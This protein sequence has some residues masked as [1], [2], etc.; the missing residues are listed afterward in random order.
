MSF[1]FTMEPRVSYLSELLKEI[2]E[3]FLKIPRFQRELVWKP[4]QQRDLLCSIFE[5]LP[6]GALLVW[7]T[8]L[9]NINVYDRIGPFPVR[10]DVISGSNLYLMDGL[11]RLSTLYGTLIYPV[12][13]VEPSRRGSLKVKELS[14]YCDLSAVDVENLFLFESELDPNVRSKSKYV[15]MPL[16]LVFKSKELLR[17]QRTIPTDKEELLDRSDAIVTAF[18]NY[19][20]PVIPLESDDQ[21]LVTKSFERINSR[22]TVMS[23]AHMLNAL[24]YSDEFDLLGSI[25]RNREIFL[26]GVPKWRDIDPE[27]VL[28]LL[29]LN[30]GFELYSKDTDKLAKSINN[31]VVAEVFRAISKLSLF[32]ERYLNIESPAEFPY[33]L[34]MLGVAHAYM[35]RPKVSYIRLRSWFYITTYTNSFGTTARNSQRALFDLKGY[36][37]SGALKWTLSHKPVI[38]SLDGIQVN[39]GAARVKAWTLALRKKYASALDYPDFDFDQRLSPMMPKEFKARGR[40]PGF[41]FL[42]NADQYKSFDVGSLSEDEFDAHFVNAKLLKLY[43]RK[44]YNGFALERERLMFL[45][46]QEN[47][48]MPAATTAKIHDMIK[49]D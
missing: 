33:R 10:S 47:I 34:Q 12:D 3:G 23:E 21:A 40:R 36:L 2:Y 22:G 14:V 48:I 15:Y 29:K 8:R 18:K 13:E 17:F 30:L 42:L 44:D 32:A 37:T 16:S 20:I 41:Y 24:S 6:I 38:Q 25:E 39:T 26:E 4:Q 9:G 1:K 31:D 7:N 49:I 28:M 5:G 11:Q 46:E 45:Y 19:K 43:A 27:F 35:E